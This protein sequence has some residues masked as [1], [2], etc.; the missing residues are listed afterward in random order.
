ML[1]NLQPRIARRRKPCRL[2]D[3]ISADTD[4]VRILCIQSCYLK[5]DIAQEHSCVEKRKT[6]LVKTCRTYNE[7]QQKHLRQTVLPGFLILILP[8]RAPK[9][10]ELTFARLVPPPNAL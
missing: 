8:L 3:W 2:S 1:R 5:T 9:T 10:R 7:Q 6:R 4:R